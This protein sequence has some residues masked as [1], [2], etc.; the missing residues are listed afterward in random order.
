MQIGKWKS[1]QGA[2][3]SEPQDRLAA[4]PVLFIQQASKKGGRR[5][6]RR[7]ASKDNI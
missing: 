1:T 3:Q 7:M 5:M 6:S 2:P 4:S